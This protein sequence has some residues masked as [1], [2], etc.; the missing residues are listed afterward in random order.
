M[1]QRLLDTRL[2]RAAHRAHC[3]FRRLLKDTHHHYACLLPMRTGAVSGLL[4]KL[5]FKGISLTPKQTAV[6]G[7]LPPE[8]V[9]V[10]V[11]KRESRF[12]R[13]FYYT[14]YRE[15]GHPVP[16]IAFDQ[17]TWIWQPVSRIIRIAL[18]RIDSVLSSGRLPEPYGSGYLENELLTGRTALLSLTGRREFHRRFV[19][20]KIDPLEFLIDMQEKTERPVFLVPHLMMFGKRPSKSAFR[21]SDIFFGSERHPGLIRKTLT[22]FRKPGQIFVEISE[23][24]N[25]REYLALPLA[26][27]RDRHHIALTL[28]R[29]LLSQ[30]NRHRQSIIGPVLKSRFELKQA[31]LTSPRFGSFMNEIAISQGKSLQK[32]RQK[33]N[34]YYGEIAA[35]YNPLVIQCFEAVL[36]WIIRNMFDGVLLDQPGLDR[37][38]RMTV[39][40]PVVLLPCHKSHID[41]LM[42]SYVMYHN[43]MPCPHVVAGKNLSFWPLGPIFRS[44]GAF[45]MRRTFRDNPL[46]AGTFSGYVSKLLQEGFNIEVFIEGGRS[47][48]GKLLSPRTGFVSILLDAVQSGACRDLILAP[49]FIG[50]DKVPE[51]KAYLHELEGGDK[52]PESLSQVIRARRLL[53]KRFGKIYIEFAD[54][55]V[56]SELLEVKELSLETTTPSERDAFCRYI[57]HR[58][59]NAINRVSVITPHCVMAASLLNCEKKRF[60]YETVADIAE[61]Y[62]RYLHFSGAKLADTLQ[63]DP[64]RSLAQAFDAYLQRKYIEQ[65]SKEV[66]S[67]D[68]ESRFQVVDSRRPGLEYYK[69]NGIAPFVPVAFTAISLLSLDAFQFASSDVHDVFRFLRDLFK[70]EFS[71]DLE[72]PPEFH[73]RRSIKSF[74]DDAVLMPH[75]TL[76]DTY[77]ITAAGFRKLRL[78]AHFCRS[79]LEAYGVVA[80]YLSQ[81]PPE[82]LSA[83]EH[84]KKIETHGARMLKRGGIELR[85]TLSRITFKNALK[86]YNSRDIFGKDENAEL[87][88]YVTRI[89]RFLGCFH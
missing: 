77:N 37:V 64:D 46:Y 84:L 82:G 85:E 50:Y 78:Y 29:D 76:P 60:A 51:E 55:M 54:P 12:E 57:G 45:F 89:N 13:L 58:T 79:Y 8:S 30:I 72:K 36:T 31:L 39:K 59:I 21:V 14:R 1:K 3:R 67:S 22:L 5:F 34:D 86:F 87:A 16:T 53:K 2:G 20:Q 56:L 65:I 52:E 7:T 81:T 63:L 15:T 40:G 62:C 71:Y 66:D 69:N 23:P 17:R 28:R 10:L 47:R 70:Y 44:S 9:I 42:L 73:V 27:G 68:P 61:T 33:A 32:I 35:K 24:L 88:P 18:S 48:T 38:K 11:N 43:D 83:S 49:V 74:I 6:F 80:D 19:E 4:L 26:Q 41:Y 75:P 25:L